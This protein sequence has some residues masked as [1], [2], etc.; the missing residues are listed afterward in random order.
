MNPAPF[1]SS[2]V[3]PPVNPVLGALVL[4]DDEDLDFVLEGPLA[5]AWQRIYYSGNAH[6]GW[7][8]RGW[9]T[10]F[11]VQLLAVPDQAGVGVDRLECVDGFGRVLTLPSLPVGGVHAVVGDGITLRRSAQGSYSLETAEGLRYDFAER[12]G[13]ACALAA[14][15]DRN[16]NAI[17]LDRT[18]QG[19]QREVIRLSCSGGQQVALYLDGGRLRQVAQLRPQGGQWQAHVLCRYEYD[20]HGNLTRVFNRAGECMRAFKYN[21]EQLLSLHAYAGSFE[22]WFEYEAINGQRRIVKHGDNVG[23]HWRL[24]Y[25][26]HQTAV[27]DQDGRTWLFHVDGQQR[28]TGLTD[29]LGHVTRYGLD[30]HGKVR[31]VIDPL[32]HVTETIYDD[33]SNP[34]EI[35]DPMGGV[36]QIEWHPALGLPV[37][38]VDPLGRTSKFEYDD[39]GNLVSETEADGST[40][41]YELSPTGLPVKITDARGGINKLAYNA[42]GQLTQY[43]DCA[44]RSTRYEY[45]DNGWL[46]AEVD[47]Q[48]QLTRYEYNAAGR[49]SRVVE[50]DGSFEAYETDLA[51]RPLLIT[52]AVGAR[53]TI[54]YAPDGLPLE[55]VDAMGGVLRLSYTTSR[56]LRQLINENGASHLFG[57][58]AVD[59]L[60][61]KVMFDGGRVN[62]V[63]DAAGRIVAT[64]ESPDATAA[65]L[66]R[67]RRDPAGR[68]LERSTP[69]TATLFTY[70]LAG[71]LTQARNRHSW[72]QFVYDDVGQIVEERLHTAQG[73]RVLKHEH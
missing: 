17:R 57:Y 39:K 58:D 27:T 61:E 68:L 43:T 25:E 3:G 7:L 11:E 37:A 22:A 33:N 60:I 31:A 49:L 65:I 59:R 32:E 13:D 19:A 48:G 34:V 40:T 8:G 62:Y 41:A 24:R 71:Q 54:T 36:T 67:Y 44:E 38:I 55:L 26:P 18:S 12:V 16:G 2:S 42:A 69:S 46:V 28:W 6:T 1:A 73:S 72:T 35:R 21:D 23:Q 10:Q 52:N 56:Q 63:Y 20:G 30:R 29:P 70:D 15:V 50:A 45:D 14:V 51:D 9:R 64:V 47:A 5:L 66:T 4:A 53:T